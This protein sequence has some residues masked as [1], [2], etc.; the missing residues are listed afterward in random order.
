M[1]GKSTTGK[2]CPAFFSW[3]REMQDDVSGR[4]RRLGGLRLRRVVY[5]TTWPP[6]RWSSS[7][8]A[9]LWV[10]CGINLEGI[11]RLPRRYEKLEA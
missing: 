11:T 6:A 3:G 8:M 4:V 9:W 5:W 7:E 2:I 1:G 10:K